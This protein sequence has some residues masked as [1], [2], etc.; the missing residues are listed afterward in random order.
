MFTYGLPK[1]TSSQRT[2]AGSQTDGVTYETSV[3]VPDRTIFP[4]ES[5]A[6]KFR[7]KT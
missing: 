2:P 5:L 6:G 4:N 1:S 7:E 3:T